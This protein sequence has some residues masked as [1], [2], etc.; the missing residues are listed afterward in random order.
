MQRVVVKMQEYSD[1][2]MEEGQGNPEGLR[3]KETSRLHPSQAC[4]A[5][6]QAPPHMHKSPP[7]SLCFSHFFQGPA[8]PKSVPGDL[9]PQGGHPS[10]SRQAKREAGS[11]TQCCLGQS[12]SPP[13]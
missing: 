4:E 3:E 9:R 1:S 6:G 5:I 13:L 11:Q 12:S 10:C 8:S 2:K 7:S